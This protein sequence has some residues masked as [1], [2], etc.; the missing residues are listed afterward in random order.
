[1]PCVRRQ[2]WSH[3]VRSSDSSA[4]GATSTPLPIEFAQNGIRAVEAEHGFEPPRLANYLPQ[5]TLRRGLVYVMYTNCS[6][7]SQRG[8]AP[9]HQMRSRR[10]SRRPERHQPD[11]RG[12][13][14]DRYKPPPINS[15][16]HDALSMA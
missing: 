15:V 13:S 7:G 3:R 9:L 12:C 14:A 8:A 11:P 16:R 6:D 1:M 2:K 10:F 5:K 4:G